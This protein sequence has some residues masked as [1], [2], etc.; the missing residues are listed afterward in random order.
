MEGRVHVFPFDGGK[1][2]TELTCADCT[3]LYGHSL[4]VG[5]FNN[6]NNTNNTN[7][8]NDGL[9]LLPSHHN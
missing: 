5:A 3:A 7:N 9:V 4:L 6:T 8:N 1:G 2:Y